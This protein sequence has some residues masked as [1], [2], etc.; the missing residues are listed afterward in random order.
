MR[1]FEHLAHDLLLIYVWGSGKEYGASSFPEHC[2]EILILSPPPPHCPTNS[3]PW[4]FRQHQ[5]EEAREE[6]HAG[7]GSRLSSFGQRIP[8]SDD[9]QEGRAVECVE[10]NSWCAFSPS[11]L[12]LAHFRSLDLFLKKKKGKRELS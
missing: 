9:E 3:L 2:L 1:S 7:P 11:S 5:E 12:G 4:A 6:V 8:A 10:V